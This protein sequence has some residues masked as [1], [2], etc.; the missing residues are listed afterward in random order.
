VAEPD[1]LVPI[2]GEWPEPARVKD[3]EQPGGYDMTSGPPTWT[4][5]LPPPPPRGEGYGLAVGDLPPPPPPATE[6]NAEPFAV[7]EAGPALPREPF[8]PADFQKELDLHHQPPPPPPPFPLWSGLYTFPWR[9]AN[10]GVWFYLSLNFSLLA[11]IFTTF[12]LLVEIGGVAMIAI[13][14]LLPVMGFIFF[15]TGIYAASC[16]L[17]IVEDTAAGND[18]VAWPKGGGL[19]DGL[20]KFIVFLWLGGSGLIPVWIF[21]V[22]GGGMAATDDFFWVV[23]VLPGIVLF[24]VQLLSVLTAG[25]WWSLLDRRII[26]GLLT[27]PLA[28]ML[29][30]VPP[31]ILITPCIWLG[32]LIIV[33]ANFPVAIVAG[34]VW[35]AFLLIYARILGRTGWLLIGTGLKKKSGKKRPRRPKLEASQAG[36]GD[37][38]EES[39]QV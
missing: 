17:A 14:L 18:Q 34:F 4:E 24:P 37:S 8:L 23:A 11:V 7:E 1:G 3:E 27:K 16:F 5:P 26:V 19:V 39:G 21:W 9:K 15:W 12:A 31:L 13:P 20:G 10:A 29:M 35:A 32:Q 36:W 28:L 38:P 6:P 25:S 30:C 2:E 33:R 22:A